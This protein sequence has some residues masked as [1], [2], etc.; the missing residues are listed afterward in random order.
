MG[1]L[2]WTKEQDL[3]LHKQFCDTD[4]KLLAKELEKTPKQV[5]KRAWDLGLRKSG[6]FI[7][8]IRSENS[9]KNRKCSIC[10][11]RHQALGFCHNHYQMYL[12][13]TID[14]NGDGDYYKSNLWLEDE[15]KALKK[16]Y[17]N[18]S[19]SELMRIFP[20]RSRRSI[21]TKA[22]KLGLSKSEIGLKK[23]HAEKMTINSKIKMSCSLRN[24]DIKDFK[25][26]VSPINI[27]IRQ[28]KKY[29]EWRETIF[30]RD[31]FV[32]FKCKNTKPGC[33]NV[34]HIIPLSSLISS[35]SKK[36]D[37]NIINDDYFYDLNNGVTVCEDCHKNLHCKI[38]I[39]KEKNMLQPNISE[40][41][42]SQK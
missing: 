25:G 8:E 38:G 4:T 23:A 20:N 15:I 11:N 12:R 26:F 2:S 32:C 37:Q 3:I 9:K 10:D 13:G 42:D 21:M 36:L 41:G 40:K 19:I 28:G 14:I 1:R 34:H 22:N 18:Y 39:T 27:L 24:I 33:M 5:G 17:A 30:K 16:F 29:F 35:Y 7:K 31:N 6:E